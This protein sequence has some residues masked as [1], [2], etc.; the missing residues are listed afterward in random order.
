MREEP[1][2]RPEGGGDAALVRLVRRNFRYKVISVALAILLYVIAYMQQN[3]RRSWDVYVQP[4]VIGLP[5]NLVVK[6]PLRPFPVTVSGLSS[7][8]DDLRVQ[9]IRATVDV[10]G[11]TVGSSKMPVK[12]HL[13]S[14]VEPRGRG[15]C[16]SPWSGRSVRCSPWSP[17]A[18]RAASRVLYK[19]PGWCSRRRF[20][21]PAGSRIWTGWSTWSQRGHE[22]GRGY[23]R[24][25]GRPGGAGR[26]PPGGGRGR[27]RVGAARVLIG[28][29][30]SPST[31]EVA[32]PE[33]V[34]RVAPGFQF[35]GY[36]LE[37]Q[38]VLLA[39]PLQR[40]APLTALRVPVSLEGL[41]SDT[42]RTLTVQ[43]PPG[44]RVVGSPQVNV[45]LRVGPAAGSQSDAPAGPANPP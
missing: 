24:R 12:Y 16:P 7:A 29:K 43:P 14:R 20:P 33:F 15:C 34:G 23:H 17:R 32:F 26:H 8:I 18:R 9:G 21:S 45:T 6:D 1:G 39:G 25:P 41:S 5:R 42:T 35:T 3:P 37:P 22:P 4:E 30:E 38:T 28:L 13:P 10:S 31:K 40:V 36:Q 2:A 11:A 44:L 27:D 19:Q